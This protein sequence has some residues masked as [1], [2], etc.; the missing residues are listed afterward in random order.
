MTQGKLH[1]LAP[2]CCFLPVNEIAPQ[3][4]VCSRESK[5]NQLARAN[6]LLSFFDMKGHSSETRTILLQLKLFPSRTT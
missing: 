1:T 6:E 2:E 4:Y 5:G 3:S